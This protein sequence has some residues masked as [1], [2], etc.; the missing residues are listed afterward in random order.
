MDNAPT[1]TF[2]DNGDDQQI[3]CDNVS[4]YS[5]PYSAAHQNSLVYT[6]NCTLFQE[7]ITAWLSCNG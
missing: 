1:G 2:V 3:I 5:I 6:F 7:P 4:V